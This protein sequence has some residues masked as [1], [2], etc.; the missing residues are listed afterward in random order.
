MNFTQLLP[1]VFF[2]LTALPTSDAGRSQLVIWDVGQG[3]WATLATPNTCIHVDA[4]GERI[5]KHVRRFC[6]EKQNQIHLTHWD[7]DHIQFLPWIRK[8]LSNLCAG[9]LPP[10]EPSRSL[11]HIATLAWSLKKCEASKR[12]F[13]PAL[14]TLEN[15]FILEMAKASNAKSQIF[16]FENLAILPGDSGQKEEKRWSRNIK[17]CP[18]ILVLGHHGSR[19]STSKTLLD[20]MK[21][22]SLA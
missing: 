15:E 21:C 10:G 12:Q 1:L 2:L 19:T 14:R 17:S 3:A 8:N 13:S 22:L 11:R 7:R 18:R 20:K 6:S 9:S 16:E 5:P 4:G